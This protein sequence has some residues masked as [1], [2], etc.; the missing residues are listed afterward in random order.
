IQP[1]NAGGDDVFVT[2]LSSAGNT[3]AYSTYVGGSGTDR[4]NGIAVDSGGNAYVTGSTTS[5]NF[6]IFPTVNPL[7]ATYGGAGSAVG[8]PG[9]AFVLKVGPTVPPLGL[10]LSPGSQTLNPGSQGTLTLT[11][12]PA[13]SSG[14]SV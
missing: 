13:Q 9:D 10:S 1:S 11:I 12:N 7:Q 4:G 2:K 6:P 8:S 14:I 3:L 5:T